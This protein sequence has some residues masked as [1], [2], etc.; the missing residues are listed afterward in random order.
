MSTFENISLVDS[1]ERSSPTATKTLTT[2]P[3]V[4]SIAKPSSDETDSD[5]E[6]DVTGSRLGVVRVV[7]DDDEDSSV[8]SVSTKSRTLAN[9]DKANPPAD[10]GQIGNSDARSVKNFAPPVQHTVARSAQRHNRNDDDDDDVDDASFGAVGANRVLSSSSRQ[11]K[12]SLND[13]LLEL[14]PRNTGVADRNDS[15]FLQT[16]VQDPKKIEVPDKGAH[17]SYSVHVKVRT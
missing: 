2:K 5:D 3:P 16:K 4:T 13:S 11:S 1:Y 17:M 8:P 14:A 12:T 9:S 10:R 7:I 15:R 6:R